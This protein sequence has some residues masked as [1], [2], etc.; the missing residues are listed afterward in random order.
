VRRL[1]RLAAGDVTDPL[2]P[3]P[4]EEPLRETALL[5][6]AVADAARLLFLAKPMTD[7]LLARL[8]ERR[9]ALAALVLRL[10]LDLPGG[11]A[12][13]RTEEIRPAAPTLDAAQL[14]R[15]RLE[16]VRLGAGASEVEV[17][18]RAVPAGEDQLRLFAETPRRDLAAADRALARLR[19]EF[20]EDAVVRARL[21]EAHLPE[22]SFAWERLDRAAPPRPRTVAEPTLVRRLLARPEA[23]PPRPRHEPD[24]WMLRG[25]EHGPVVRF[26][27]PFVVSGGWWAG[28][29]VRREGHFA[30]TARGHLFQVFYDVRRRRWF[31][32]GEVD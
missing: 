24:G 8:A 6:D 14:L 7:R 32:A 23:L 17:A 21:R 25:F 20:G 11:R 9:Q 16:S 10:R 2:L 28:E 4:A 12:E 22:A 26:D 29:E 5:D 30:E 13:D 31:L 15:L 27:G 19:A 3:E 18:A 1:H